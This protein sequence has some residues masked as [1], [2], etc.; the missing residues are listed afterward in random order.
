M[1]KLRDGLVLS[2]L[3]LNLKIQLVYYLY[4][5]FLYILPFTTCAT[6]III[7][8]PFLFLILLEIVPILMQL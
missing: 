7:V 3:I 8:L 2:A 6:T 5:S 1:G 4:G